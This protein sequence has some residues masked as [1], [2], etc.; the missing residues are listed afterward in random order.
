MDAESDAPSLPETVSPRKPAGRGTPRRGGASGGR[1]RAVGGDDALLSLKEQCAAARAAERAAEDKSRHLAAQLARTEEAAKRILTRT[2]ASAR[3]GVAQRLLDAERDLAAAQAE[4]AELR[5]QWAR[6]KRVAGERKRQAADLQQRLDAALA[7]Q[8]HLALQLGR[9]QAG[10]GRWSLGGAAGSAVA[11]AQVPVGQ[12]AVGEEPNADAE[13]QADADARRFA[14]QQ[15]ELVTAQEQQRRLHA[16]VQQ[17]A[18]VMERQATEL[19]ALREQLAQRGG[20][21]ESAPHPSAP[22][23]GHGLPHAGAMQLGITRPHGCT[24]DSEA[25]AAASAAGS[26]SLRLRYLESRSALERSTHSNGK[27]L[28]QLDGARRE[29][30]A[31][32]LKV[33]QQQQAAE[34]QAGGALP[35]T[36]TWQYGGPSTTSWD[37]AG[38]TPGSAPD[39]ARQAPQPASSPPATVVLQLRQQLAAAEHQAARLEIELDAAQA[40]LAVYE[41]QAQQEAYQAQQPLTF[42][43]ADVGAATAMTHVLTGTEVNTLLQ[44]ELGQAPLAE[45]A[46]GG[47]GALVQLHRCA[48]GSGGV[49]YETLAS[50]QVPLGGLLAA[51]QGPAAAAPRQRCPLYRGNQVVGSLWYSL[52]ARGAPC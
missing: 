49:D 27:L 39:S 42:L 9:M 21:R 10:G 40:K 30:Q 44:F 11:R 19:A 13:A 24:D 26:A 38:S 16:T 17:Q 3:G 4:L 41:Q 12:P 29:V 33:R 2:D 36:G 48:G 46:R 18:A 50:A 47:G 1:S 31:L 15:E 52:A 32:R 6:T 20:G 43:T 45:L 37:E 14:L 23:P 5:S 28:R 22:R 35:V 8:R 51:P 34:L 7:A 25:G